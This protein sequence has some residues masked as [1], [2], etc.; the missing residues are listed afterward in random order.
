MYRHCI[1]RLQQEGLEQEREPVGQAL[2]RGLH[3]AIS[4][5]I[6]IHPGY[7]GM[8]QGFVLEEVQMPPC[9]HLRVVGLEPATDAQLLVSKGE[10]LT[11]GKVY[12]DIQL[13]LVEVELDLVTELRAS[14]INALLNSSF[15]PNMYRCFSQ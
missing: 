2:P 8:E 6:Y 5:L 9:L 1:H 13:A 4:S 12:P 10:E 11:A 7:A 3:L 15:V 14:I